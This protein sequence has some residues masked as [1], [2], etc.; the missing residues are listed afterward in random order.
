VF[1]VIE[2]HGGR[3]FA[4][5]RPGSEAE[6]EQVNR[7]LEQDRIDAYGPADYT[8]GSQTAMWLTQTVRRIADRI[9]RDRSQAL[10]ERLGAPPGHVSD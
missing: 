4:V 8:E 1:S 3:T 10:T 9:V 6:F 7:L 5:Y 2:K